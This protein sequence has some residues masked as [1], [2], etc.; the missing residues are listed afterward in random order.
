M[1]LRL[2]LIF[3]ATAV[4][5]AGVLAQEQVP[6]NEDATAV[7]P[8]PAEAKAPVESCDAH[9]FETTVKIMAAEGK[10][11][12][13]KVRLCGREGQTDADWVGTLKDAVKKLEAN[14]TMAATTREQVIAALKTEISKIEG[15][16][17]S[18]APPIAAASTLRTEM[19]AA[20]VKPAERPP[21]YAALPRLPRGPAAARVSP[22]GKPAVAPIKPRLTIRCLSPGELG[23]GGPCDSLGKYTVLTVRADENLPSAYRLRF[24]RKGDERGELALAQLRKGQSLRSRVPQHLCAG[25]VRSTVQIEVRTRGG[26]QVADTLGPYDLRC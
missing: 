14:S 16:P 25:V 17:A 7:R 13:S 4:M 20:I 2:A 9:K 24:L 8:L 21:E 12:S 26:N 3:A 18:S 23:R 22:S 19:P 1:T 10:V 15:G 6:P 5:P 11:R